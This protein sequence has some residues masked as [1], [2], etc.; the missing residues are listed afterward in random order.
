MEPQGL[1]S[2]SLLVLSN[3]L[4]SDIRDYSDRMKKWILNNKEDSFGGNCCEYVKEGD[5]IKIYHSYCE[6]LSPLVINKDDIMRVLDEWVTLVQA[7]AEKIVIIENDGKKISVVPFE[8]IR[9]QVKSWKD[10]QDL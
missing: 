7:D 10:I 2:D 1:I 3:F 5:I 6:G 9:E 8:S 4:T